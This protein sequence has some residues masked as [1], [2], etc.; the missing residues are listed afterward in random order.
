MRKIYFYPHEYLRDRQLETIKSWPASDV[1]NPEIALNRVGNQVDK[2]K[3]ISKKLYLSWK[4][5]FPLLNIKWH[6]RNLDKNTILYIWGGITIKGLFVTELDNPWS[7][8]GYNIKAMRYYSFFIKRI[9]NS[10]R[11]VQIKCMSEACRKSLKYLFGEEVYKKSELSYPKVNI[12]KISK[13]FNKNKNTKFLFVGTQF[14]L[15]GG[16]ALIKSFNKAYK[17]NPNISLDIITHVPRRFNQN[18]AGIRFFPANFSKEEIYRKFMCKS[19]VLIH[20][21]YVDTFGVV[22]L[23]AIAHGLGIISTD[24]YALPEMVY[25]DINGIILN[26]PISIW[27]GYLPSKHYKNLSNIKE[28][29][30]N[31]DT[32]SFEKELEKSILKFSENITFRTKAKEASR[33]IYLDK[34]QC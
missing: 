24:L 31:I 18:Y 32:Y 5:K 4:Q 16:K 17:K 26:P 6:P 3:A 30:D 22:V 28:S 27:D 1:I 15:K 23:E 33:K 20:P 25:E 21:T 19:D 12:D 34:F 2:K 8:V 9:L 11:C 7:L 10:E 13:N 14:E 29:I